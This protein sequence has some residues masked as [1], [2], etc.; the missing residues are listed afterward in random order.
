MNER[1]NP[2]PDK[3]EIIDPD[4]AVAREICGLLARRFGYDD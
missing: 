3:G 4:G 2:A 1:V